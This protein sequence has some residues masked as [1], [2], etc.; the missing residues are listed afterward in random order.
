MAK[1]RVSTNP[2]YTG[3]AGGYSF[4][5]RGGEQV[6]RQRRNNS[7]Y[8]ESA[9]RSESQM[10]RRVKWAN[11]VNMYKACKSWMP[12]AFEVKEKG[13]TDYNLFMSMNI[14]D[15]TV[16]LTKDMALNGCAVNS[17]Q[18]VS[19]GSL[20][21]IELYEYDTGVGHVL[22]LTVTIA[23]SS[24]TTVG[25]FSTNLI[26]NNPSFKNGDNL[27]IIIFKNIQDARRFPYLSTKYTEVTLDTT[28]NATLF[29]ISE[30][31]RL[32][33]TN[34]NLLKFA[35][36]ALNSYESGAA[37]IHTRRVSGVLQVSTQRVFQTGEN[38][39]GEYDSDAWVQE[40]ILSYG[41]D[42]TVPLDPGEGGDV[43][44]QYPTSVSG[45]ITGNG[46]DAVYGGPVRVQPGTY[47]VNLNPYDWDVSDYADDVN[48][49]TVRCYKP[50]Y[51]G[52]G[53]DFLSIYV[54]KSE[55]DGVGVPDGLTVVVPQTYPLLEVILR[56]PSATPIAWS[57]IRIG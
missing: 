5:V 20:A 24:S 27:A 8:G 4:Y 30:M 40:C 37:F 18:Y 54:K 23:I 6:V 16:A 28:S 43:N 48:I 55:F 57:A 15:A 44:P 42:T 19:R 39:N 11:L 10:L 22:D 17:G 25:Q 51:D 49:V 34:N 41:I 13:Q 52:T 29:D 33:V 14:N 53:T 31:N 47:E 3:G 45:L 21:P 32:S 46:A 2:M 1:A 50:G 7:N 9:S 36:G 26:Q 35:C 56:A 12:K 38:I